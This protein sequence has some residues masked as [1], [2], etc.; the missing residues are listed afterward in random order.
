MA[1]VHSETDQER[2]EERRRLSQ[3]A[4]AAAAEAEE[5]ERR[6]AISTAAAS[7]GAALENDDDAMD[8]DTEAAEAAAPKQRRGRGRRAKE[9]ANETIANIEV[10]DADTTGATSAAAAASSSA[11]EEKTGASPSRYSTTAA[12]DAKHRKR[13]TEA[14]TNGTAYD[15]STS[16]AARRGHAGSSSSSSAQ[17]RDALPLRDALKKPQDWQKA[18]DAL[19]DL[20]N[21]EGG[22]VPRAVPDFN[23]PLPRAAVVRA[24]LA[25][26]ERR[27]AQ[28]GREAASA[29]AAVAAAV[30]NALARLDS[31]PGAL[32]GKSRS[33]KKT[34]SSSAQV[35]LH[36]SLGASVTGTL[37]A[38]ALV[39]CTAASQCSISASYTVAG[40]QSA[41]NKLVLHAATQ[42]ESAYMTPAACLADMKTVLER[43]RRA[44]QLSEDGREHS[45]NTGKALELST[46]T[47]SSIRVILASISFDVA[48]CS[49]YTA[50][51]WTAVLA[52]S[53]H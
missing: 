26:L 51:R 19:Q 8:V 31:G 49:L 29:R 28:A 2:H 25:K 41:L 45:G 44:A 3:I 17:N 48:H 15:S 33:S 47:S 16:A 11:Y 34:G 7:A 38:V 53:A 39:G 22:R 50:V 13:R 9:R 1:L 21:L 18:V 42:Q 46:Y 4:V 20:R 35:R 37:T 10:S 32:E 52:Y 43:N 14:S 23:A 6:A 24:A 30:P 40:V 12:A 5:A 27:I 36:T